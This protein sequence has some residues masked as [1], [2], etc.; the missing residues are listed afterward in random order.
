MEVTRV[1]SE[2]ARYSLQLSHEAEKL[3]ILT[4]V[5]ILPVINLSILGYV[6]RVIRLSPQSPALPPLARWGQMFL[7]G[8]YLFI[9][10]LSYLAAGIVVTALLIYAGYLPLLLL[11][12]VATLLGL[13]I[14][15]L[16]LVHSV[17]E[18]DP[19]KAFALRTLLSMVSRVGWRDYLAWFLGALVLPSALFFVLA[20]IP[21]IG[22]GLALL[23][24][25]AIAVFLGRSAAHVYAEANL[26]PAETGAS[27]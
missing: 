15:P 20:L 3:L 6:A 27:F 19:M 17:K 16:A 8:T 10:S 12:W 7:E 23:I 22:W 1:I 2:S 18:A 5:A 9:L 4:I 25:P 24:F 14:L 21:I 11:G 13:L 26:I